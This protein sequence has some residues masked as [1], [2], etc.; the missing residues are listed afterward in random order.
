MSFVMY[1]NGT[2]Y[3]GSQVI[4]NSSLLT[5]IR[6]ST[7]YNATSNTSPVISMENSTNNVLF[8]DFRIWAKSL[9]EAEMIMVYNSTTDA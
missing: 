7:R 8:D 5:S 9:T 1:N 2:K 6:R 3:S 4:T